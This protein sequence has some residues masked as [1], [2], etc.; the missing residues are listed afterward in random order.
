M[1]LSIA[2]EVA[3]TRRLYSHPLTY[4]GVTGIKRA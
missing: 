1:T 4:Q 2:T 3:A